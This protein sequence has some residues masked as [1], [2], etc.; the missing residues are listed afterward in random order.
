MA[1]TA[2]APRKRAS[3]STKSNSTR[4]AS[5]SNGTAKRK[6]ASTRSKSP[7]STRSKPQPPV[8]QAAQAVAGVASKAKTPLIAGGT[9]LVG[10]AAG[11]LAKDRL[12]S[13]RSKNPLKRIGGAQIDLD[14]VK[15]AADRVSVYGRQ[16]SDIASAV[17]KARK[18]NKA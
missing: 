11:V 16:A 12:N 6:P 18:K 7:S 9:A 5:S 2:K 13:K 1:Q 17:Q 3:G 8:K 14:K 4:R 10:A 15:S